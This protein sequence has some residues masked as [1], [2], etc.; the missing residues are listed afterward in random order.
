MS[1]SVDQRIVEMQFDNASFERGI[2]STMAS[3]SNL[4]SLLS[5]TGLGKI[6]DALSNVDFSTPESRISSIGALLQSV[7]EVGV[8]AF[9]KISNAMA[10]VSKVGAGV[11]AVLNTGVLGMAVQKSWSRASSLADA[12]FKFQMLDQNWEEAKEAIQDSVMDTA[13]GF[14]EA[15]VAAASLSA[16]GITAGHGLAETLRAVANLAS[17]SGI[18]YSRVAQL[19]GQVASQGKLGGMQMESFSIAGINL[20]GLMA[21][22]WGTTEEEVRELIKKGEIDITTFVDVMNTKLGEGAKKA[23]GTFSGSL[24]NMKG[25]LGRQFAD[26]FETGQQSMVPIFDAMR[27]FFSMT[28]NAMKPFLGII[29]GQEGVLIR[30]FRNIAA[31]IGGAIKYYVK[32][33]T[34]AENLT[35]IFQGLNDAMEGFFASVGAGAFDFTYSMLL[36]MSVF[37]EL[38][39]LLGE[40]VSPI[41]MALNDAFGG[42]QFANAMS[43][44][45]NS[46]QGLL[47]TLSNAHVSTGYINVMRT[48]FGA[49]FR[50]VSIAGKA[51]FA[52]LGAGFTL[53]TKVVEIAANVFFGFF[54]VV[55]MVASAIG[56]FFGTQVLG[57]FEAIAGFVSGLPGLSALGDFLGGLP[58][59][60]SELVN[61]MRDAADPF[62]VL[63]SFFDK[64]EEMGGP[65]FSEV[66]KGLGAM[67]V[68]IGEFVSGL[69]NAAMEKAVVIFGRI[70]DVLGRVWLKVV[71][72]LESVRDRLAS[73]WS[74]ITE[75]VASSGLSFEPIANMFSEF[76][77]VFSGFL[78]DVLDNGFSFESIGTL[79]SGLKDAI[80]PAMEDISKSVGFIA[81]SIGDEIY[82]SMSPAIQKLWDL[83]SGFGSE[84]LFSGLENVDIFGSLGNILTKQASDIAS[85]DLTS[86]GT[87]A[88]DIKNTISHPFTTASKTLK[89]ISNDFGKAFD[90]VVSSIDSEKLNQL[91]AGIGELAALAGVAATFYE[92]MK[93][94]DA[95]SKMMESAG[96]MLKSFG[97]I[98]K[99]INT[100]VKTLSKAAAIKLKT[101]FPLR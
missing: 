97:E 9:E 15:A 8:G 100:A 52:I 66:A 45:R 69:K 88:T 70:G 48:V 80:V 36:L 33:T 31:G 87:I 21:Q 28:S 16:S 58:E 101:Q 40:V 75:A 62:A 94:L 35:R 49:F 42:D 59:A 7:G 11:F 96:S 3:L 65:V 98:A 41:F 17:V 57:F 39:R 60:I 18:E 93:V 79:I 1:N 29:N 85:I 2:A 72:V 81:S 91:V 13:Y 51:A 78:D 74:V 68:S 12:K 63:Q 54:N 37:R 53:V 89:D 24:A 55:D 34:A 27:D 20:A 6:G 26:L 61:S 84:D 30:G 50:V 38:A 71:P 77:N 86:I 99:S 32:N 90:T 83:L 82:N 14:D 44:T 67:A 25:A 4:E 46:L 95:A 10:T 92:S 73:L 76:G 64:V 23:Q 47:E 43:A 5:K 56:N 19:M 22:A